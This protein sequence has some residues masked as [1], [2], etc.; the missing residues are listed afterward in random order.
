M[1][2]THRAFVIKDTDLVERDENSFGHFPITTTDPAVVKQAFMDFVD[3]IAG[4]GED[5]VGKAGFYMYGARNNSR[6]D[7]PWHLYDLD[8][9]TVVGRDVSYDMTGAQYSAMKR[10]DAGFGQGTAYVLQ[11]Y[12]VATSRWI[13]DYGRP[14]V[15]IDPEGDS[16]PAPYL[17]G[18]GN[19]SGGTDIPVEVITFN[20][21]EAESE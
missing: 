6:E 17:R 13:I 4:A 8:Y 9:D 15:I 21:E 10:R 3:S 5:H 7:G 20:E 12:S 16:P 14:T 2:N 18:I 19:F 11:K 1:A